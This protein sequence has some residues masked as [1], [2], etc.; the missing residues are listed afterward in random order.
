M[1]KLFLFT[2]LF[3][4]TFLHSKTLEV[5]TEEFYKTKDYMLYTLAEDINETLDSL[6]SKEWFDNKKT[7]NIPA[8]ASKAYW[9]KLKLKN[10]ATQPIIYYL[11]SE[12]Q[13][14]Y[15]IIYYLLK[16]GKVVE[17]IED[18]VISK[19]PKREFNVN[20]MI[21]PLSLASGEEAE[22]FFKIQNYN[23]IDIDFS[24][25]TK[26]YLLDFYQTYNLLEG[27]FFGGMLMMMFYNLFLY[28][29][30]KFRAYLY[31][32]LYTFWLTVY[33]AGL[34]GFSQRYFAGYTWIFY[35]SSGAFFVSMTLFIQ[36]ILN[37]KEQLPKINKIL[38]YFMIYFIVATLI[39]I[40]VLEFEQFF[41][42]QVL[43]NLF[44]ML[45]PLYVTLVIL[46]TY[47][48]AYFKKDSVARIYSWV[49]TI[50]SFVGLLLPLVYLNIIETDIPS[51]YIFQFLILFEVLCFSFILA[52]KIKIIQKEQSEQ[53][54]LLVE[55][56]KLA[57]MGEMISTIAHQWRQPLSE[58]NGVVLKMDIDYRKEKL[59]EEKFNNHL[60]DIERIT[61][62]LSKTIHD[63]MN[64]FSHKK[65]LEEFLLR[66]ALKSSKR[67]ASLFIKEKI[68]FSNI[69]NINIKMVGYQSELIQALLIVIH[70]SIDAAR[71][72]KKLAVII[73]DI[74]EIDNNIHINIEDNGGGISEKIL[75]DI[76]NPYF[77][78]KHES[79][80]TGLG[81]YILKMIIEESMS[82]TVKI[83]NKNKGVN[84][85]I[86]IP[87]KLGKIGT[88]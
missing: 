53:Q 42:A 31:Y 48:L 41:Y 80:G 49:W 2:F 59:T 74:K 43:F 76:F 44:F 30:L 61:S 70:N 64:L 72:K 68:T 51:D 78:T 88:F 54:V 5:G 26:E 34:F 66:D 77:T 36:A 24:L 81:L 8:N 71:S 19:N 45:V 56:S 21:F 18:G 27:L 6:L 37:L 9:A 28:F 10:I 73:I 13:F 85:K 87:K 17:R 67:L 29:L 40:I 32:V 82:G 25:V 75:K 12:N 57:S 83:F 69:N 20:H 60:N 3:F 50:V 1:R 39:N 58:I 52:Y 33:F 35:I 4:F 65:E 38:N 55:Q 63:F 62:Y 14:T 46:V 79:Q 22:V 7:F 84:C 16:E 23:K 86:V 15:H 11:K 47:Y